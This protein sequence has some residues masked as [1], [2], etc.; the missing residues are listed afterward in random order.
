MKIKESFV[1]HQ[2]RNDY[3]M[4]DA[5]G[6]SNSIIHG[7]KTTAFIVECLRADTTRDEIVNKML[8]KYNVSVDDAAESADLVIETL[9]K[10]NAIVE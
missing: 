1:V 2:N 8:E 10:H 6:E 9:K 3:I 7:N 5:A 4:I